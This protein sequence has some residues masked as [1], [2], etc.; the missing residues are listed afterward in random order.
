MSA[1]VTEHFVLQSA[2]S[3]TVSEAS[4]RASLYMLSL[5]SS[6]VGMG[7]VAQSTTAFTP[8]V[9]IVLPTVFVLGVFTIVRL[10]DTTIEN[11]QFMA[12][13]SR[14]RAYYRTLSPEATKF[15]APWSAKDHQLDEALASI[16]I[17]RGWL[18]S[19]FTTASMVAA[20]NGIV[21]GAGIALLI[22]KTTDALA[23]AIVLGLLAMAAWLTAFYY[24]QYYRFKVFND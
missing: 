20:I 7:F 10:V 18:A 1:L 9:A 2:A 4:S 23:V 8:F 6:L 15:F 17:R 14:I 5:S 3:T 21:G 16:G 11:L 13:V 22:F 12:G 24:Y 19:M